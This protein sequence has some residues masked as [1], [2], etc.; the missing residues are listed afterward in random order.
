MRFLIIIIFLTKC[1]IFSYSQEDTIHYMPPWYAPNSPVDRDYGR[2][3]A[4]L[5][6]QEN[7]SFDVTVKNKTNT[8]NRTITISKTNPYRL[9]LGYIQL[10]GTCP[11]SCVRVDNAVNVIL[12]D[13]TNRVLST[14]GL[15]FT[16][17][18]NF[19]VNIGHRSTDQ[20][21]IATSKGRV[22]LGKNFYTGHLHT[23][24]G[25][26]TT[27]RDRRA[28]F[29]SVMAT[30]NNTTIN[31]SN[32]NFV[33]D[34]KTSSFSITLQAYQSYVVSHYFPTSPYTDVTI[35][36]VNGTRITSNKPIA[37]ISGT[38]TGGSTAGAQ[39]MGVDEIVPVDLAGTEF[40]L[41][42]GNGNSNALENVI[43]VATTNN[44]N[45]TWYGNSTYTYSGL[46]AG[47]YYIIPGSDFSTDSTMYITSTQPVLI[48]QTLASGGNATQGMVIIPRLT[49]NAAKSVQIAYSGTIGVP[50]IQLITQSTAS[51]T[52]NGIAVS[53]ASKTI[54]GNSDW[55]GYRFTNSELMNTYLPGSD[56]SFQI[57]ST[58][59]LNAALM[60]VQNPIGGGGYYSGFGTKPSISVAPN[61]SGQGL[62]SG[63]AKITATGFVNYTWY[64][65]GSTIPGLVNVTTNEYIASSPGR[66]KVIGV[67]SCGNSFPSNELLI[68][69]CLSVNSVVTDATETA[70]GT[71]QTFTVN[72]S[73]PYTEDDVTFN[74]NT[75]SVTA[76]SG[77]DFTATSGV[78]T[79][80]AGSTSTTISVPIL[81]D[82]LAEDNET[83]QLVISSP[84]N[85]VISVTSASAT[86]LDDGD[87]QPIVNV[88]ADKSVSEADGVQ[89]YTLTLDRQSGQT[90]TVDYSISDGT[91]T[92]GNDYSVPYSGTI[93]FAPLETSK[94]FAVNITDDNV[95]EPGSS[96]TLNIALSNFVNVTAGAKTTASCTISDND[97]M[98]TVSL[99]ATNS[100]EGNNAVA[101]I[102]LSHP[103]QPIVSF[104]YQTSDLTAIQ[105]SDY[106][107]TSGNANI[108]SL[109]TSINI[110]I[111]TI[112][113][114]DIEAPESFRFSVSNFNG[115]T[116]SGS[117]DVDI[118]IFDNES[119][120]LIISD[121]SVSEG[122]AL[123][124]T[125]S[126]IGGPTGTVTFDYTSNSSTAV[127]G[128]DFTGVSGTI[129]MNSPYNPETIVVTTLE[130]FLEEGNE[131]F[132]INLSNVV[133]ATLA[134]GI[135]LGTIVDNDTLPI[136]NNDNFTINEDQTLSQNVFT[137]DTLHDWPVTI[138]SNT[139]PTNGSI[140][141]LNLN[142]GA[143]SYTPNANYSGSDGFTYTIEDTDGDQ[144][145]ATVAITIN[146][147]NDVPNAI[148]DNFTIAE[149]A[150]L[151]DN[152]KTN[153]TGMGDGGISISLVSNVSH[154]SLTLNNDG[155][156]TY[157]PTS[158]YFGTD[159]FTYELSDTNGETDNATVTITINYSNDFDPVGVD[160]TYGV[161]LNSS[162]N[163]LNVSTND[164]DADGNST[165]DL[166]SI[167]IVSGP[168]HG[169]YTL[170][171][172]GTILY[173]PTAA[174]SGT[175]VI[176]YTISDNG[177]RTSNTAT[178]NI[179]IATPTM[180]LSSNSF[181]I[182]S[183]TG[184]AL[185]TASY[186]NSLA[187]SYPVTVTYQITGEGSTRQITTN[188]G[189]LNLLAASDF[190][191][192][193]AVNTSKEVTLVSATDNN[194]IVL[195]I[196][197]TTTA[198]ITITPEPT[199]NNVTQTP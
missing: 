45:L 91:T 64:K 68:S 174:Y 126:I 46:N 146:A 125:V 42:K 13:S 142:T 81:D 157:T 63:N 51:V 185:V 118:Q 189:N 43:V 31:F 60:F 128:T 175:D 160:D 139:T 197:G 188:D 155:T 37:V 129:S 124:F 39:D 99:S 132:T 74:Y 66:Y 27:P 57:V 8:F 100:I 148:N 34:G 176:T 7:T 3:Y 35:N 186:T 191:N 21:D 171:G 159:Q 127:S 70:G 109:Q 11:S 198:T 150:T 79:I 111:P 40:I 30:E 193:T 199:L 26:S 41:Q 73:Q 24:L 122:S 113:D 140:N 178:V 1:F 95:Y 22:A 165:L 20:G 32:P 67:N 180:S 183:T 72:L 54:S 156:F 10:T 80:I 172:D 33:F 112:D 71:T 47:S 110:N 144:S 115:A 36:D 117:S 167:N 93:T 151:N 49:C 16:G 52:I 119:P 162:N 69:P 169:T 44:T 116:I 181:T 56:T 194:S 121:A 107:T 187:I 192:Q 76:S 145:T 123:S 161:A 103:S 173:T 50:V 177:S 87:P 2:H 84:V 17:S 85:A 106:S 28:H 141:S 98:P 65:D 9:D 135:G 147:V 86:I 14:E 196:S 5:S 29:V 143:L 88:S 89:T 61:I 55:K 48:Y 182:C 154:G 82:V 101:T 168:G 166:N 18:K 75:Q 102:T 77:L 78:G 25:T 38:W 92:Q 96:E 158:Q 153:D 59:A 195:T 94:T 90:I 53:K 190:R 104:D 58:G 163:V 133:N 4:I 149:N 120:Q 138:V 137:N 114:T 130:D 131:T 170:P 105:G 6:T 19:F 134:D 136:A 152:V 15:I 108:P 164:T 62:C 97:L 83:Y 179:S 23:I 184:T 12:Q